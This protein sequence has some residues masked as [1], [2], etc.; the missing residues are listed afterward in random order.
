MIERSA[1]LFVSLLVL[2]AA[3]PQ[4]S[5][6]T[7]QSGS[8]TSQGAA[9]KSGKSGNSRSSPA[10]GAIPGALPGLCF[11]PGVG[12]Q[13]MLTEQPSKAATRDTN[14]SKGLE[15]SG[16]ASGATPQSA[17]PGLSGAKQVHS[18]EC[19]GKST[20]DRVLGV[21]VDKKFLNRTAISAR[22]TTKPGREPARM[23]ALPSATSA[24]SEGEAD[25]PS[26]QPGDR[27]FHA[28]ISSIKLRRLIRNAPDLQTRMKLQQLQHNPANQLHHARV[29]TKTGRAA[30]RPLKGERVSRSSSPGSVTH[31]GPRGNPRTLLSAASR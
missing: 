21:G 16:S 31:G 12:W 9:R 15:V 28:Y 25:A 10:S 26:G 27:A 8:S 17:Y 22:S 18:T 7:A 23:T 2:L 14:A 5:P 4:A 6:Q 11:Q 29:D 19:A 1:R 3:A 30:R 13:S 20:D 24:A